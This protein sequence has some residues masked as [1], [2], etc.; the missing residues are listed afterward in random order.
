M[1]M[2]KRLIAKEPGKTEYIEQ[3]KYVADKDNVVVKT[4]R[5]GICATDISI[6]RGDAFFILDGR[7]QFPVE[8]GHEWA[9]IVTEVGPDVTDFKVGDHV[10]SD[11]GV[12]C[13]ECEACLAG[14]Y[15]KCKFHR[16][17][18]T[19]NAWPGGFCEYMKFPQR[20]LH[21]VPMELD[22][23]NAALIEPAAISYGGVLKAGVDETKTVLVVGTGAIGMC[24][25]AVAHH[26][27]AKKVMVSGRTDFKL[28]VAKQIGADVVVN[29]TQMSLEDFVKQECGD[30]GVD[31]IIECSGNVNVLNDC[32]RV[33]APRGILALAGFFERQI[34][35]LN[36][37]EFVMKEC[38]LQSVMGSVEA[39]LAC[40]KFIG[41]EGLDLRPI[42]TGRANFQD[43]GAQAAFEDIY[44]NGTK[45]V[46][47]TM[48]EFD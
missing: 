42:I 9:G 18:G 39:T 6:M 44:T 11:S 2:M 34:D 43:G 40:L 7:T 19:I 38:T 12:S 14:E 35:G 10:I 20:H 46:I 15:N 21:K 3:P 1:E 31:V 45:K 27:G 47:K 13:G 16:S 29:S 22:W 5:C 26:V 30:D 37:D 28:D 33:I 8:F 32:I 41:D 48:V 25:A 4:M 23:D 17:L 24:A 36:L